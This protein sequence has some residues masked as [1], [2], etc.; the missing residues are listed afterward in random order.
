MCL[1]FVAPVFAA[2]DL[3]QDEQKSADLSRASSV[4]DYSSDQPMLE[5]SNQPM[6]ESMLVSSK[7]PS[8]Q[9]SKPSFQASKLPSL[10]IPSKLFSYGAA[11][12]C[13]SIHIRESRC[14]RRQT[15]D[16]I[17]M[18]LDA[19]PGISMPQAADLG[20]LESMKST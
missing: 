15:S 2:N 9:A 17:S 19:Y 4:L 18:H 12:R 16:P 13:I 1:L 3:A 11:S 20:P 5:C 14:H 10:Q 6:L 7:L 8:F